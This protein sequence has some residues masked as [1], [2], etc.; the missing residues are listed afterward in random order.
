MLR[1]EHTRSNFKTVS[2]H[3]AWN[4]LVGKWLPGKPEVREEYLLYA[5]SP[6]SAQP[7]AQVCYEMR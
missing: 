2:R 1:I 5:E 4:G 6:C 3:K 7:P